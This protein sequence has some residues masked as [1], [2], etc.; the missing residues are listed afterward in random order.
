MSVAFTAV[1]LPLQ[2]E[3]DM[4]NFFPYVALIPHHVRARLNQG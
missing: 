4:V 3:K 2:T 1:F